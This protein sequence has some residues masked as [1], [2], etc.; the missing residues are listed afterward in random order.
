MEPADVLRKIMRPGHGWT[1]GRSP[2]P[3]DGISGDTP[4]VYSACS[5]DWE[6]LV[7]EVVGR[8][9]QPQSITSQFL[10]DLAKL[11]LAKGPQVQEPPLIAGN[12]LADGPDPGRIEAVHRA[13]RRSMA[14]RGMLSRWRVFSSII[15]RS[16]TR[17][18]WRR[19]SIRRALV[20]EQGRRFDPIA[21]AVPECA[22]AV[23]GPCQ[24]VTVEHERR[25]RP[26]DSEGMASATS[27][28]LSRPRFRQMRFA[29]ICQIGPARPASPRFRCAGPAA[30][31]HPR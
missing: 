5:V 6:W 23:H 7:S 18:R 3:E 27:V 11:N 25:R 4:G 19:Y 17:A 22:R 1:C 29:R 21:I 8:H 15:Y 24:N 16:R 13:N 14:A 28:G 20:L 26:D 30:P 12:E 10:F 9:L 31:G 2:P